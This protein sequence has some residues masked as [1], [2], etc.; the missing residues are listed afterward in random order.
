MSLP[1]QMKTRVY[2]DRAKMLRDALRG[3]KATAENQMA[4]A[5]AA[6]GP[7]S[8]EKKRAQA[9]F[10]LFAANEAVIDATVTKV[11]E[12]VAASGGSE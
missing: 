10:D 8:A 11:E 9:L 6:C 5:E 1:N 2:L 12:E 4:C 3:A 7:N